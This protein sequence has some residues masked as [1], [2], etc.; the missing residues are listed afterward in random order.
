MMHSASTMTSSIP[1][2]AVL[3]CHPDTDT[4]VVE[5]IKA[6][7]GWR[8]DNTLAFYYSLKG[9]LMRLRIPPPRPSRR[10]DR[11]WQ[12]TCFEA[13]VS[14]KGEAD[15]HEFNFAPSSEWAAYSFQRYRD[16]T[17]LADDRIIARITARREADRLDL[18]ATIHLDRL[19][20]ITPHAWL[21]IAVCA[22]IEDQSG[23]LS[24]WAL[25][26]P[27][28]DPDFHHPDGFALELEP[29]NMAAVNEPAVE[30]R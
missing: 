28:G 13:F 9:N 1:K 15:Y 2:K 27:R 26:H 7:V 14:V 5:E 3:T 25:R 17:P 6:D 19:P 12:H 11:L 16:G 29:A 8:Q 30:K 18:N 21:H 22:V 23:K 4:H 24:Y 20:T 10:A